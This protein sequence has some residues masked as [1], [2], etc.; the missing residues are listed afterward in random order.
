[1]S[2]DAYTQ[3]LTALSD[4]GPVRV[5]SIVISV[6]GDLAQ[7]QN[8]TIDGPVLSAILSE[9]VIKPEAAR[10]ALHRLRNEG[11][12]TSTKLGR[13]SRHALTA[14]SRRQSATASGRIYADPDAISAAWQLVLLPDTHAGTASDMKKRGFQQLTT[15]VFIGGDTAQ[16][17]DGALSLAGGTPPPWLSEQL[18]QPEIDNEYDSLLAVLTKARANLPPA[19]ALS[20]RQNAALRCMIVHCWRRIV[21]KH[22]DLPKS[23]YP[24]DWPG[25][26]C[27]RAVADFLADYP[28]PDLADII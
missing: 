5:W 7:D 21:L 20:A 23:L 3:T 18:R 2:N 14:S 17:P 8:A 4:L 15:R 19:S 28:R 10:V 25:H 12:I 9:F 6:F 16:P 22:P 1:M 24:A 27:H 11:W 26:L 13:T